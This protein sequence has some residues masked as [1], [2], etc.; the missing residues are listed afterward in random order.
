[1]KSSAYLYKLLD[2]GV[3]RRDLPQASPVSSYATPLDTVEAEAHAA[4]LDSSA[5]N[6]SILA[7]LRPA[8]PQQPKLV[9]SAERRIASMLLTIPVGNTT[10]EFAAIYEALFKTLPAN[11]KLICL[12]NTGSKRIVETWLK[13]HG[14]DSSA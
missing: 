13:K 8:Q 2:N 7:T 1:M 3:V 12:V 14:R 5:R 6:F 11:V 4:R 10:G 9:S